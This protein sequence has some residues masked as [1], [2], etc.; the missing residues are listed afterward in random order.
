MTIEFLRGFPIA[1]I[2][3]TGM[4]VFQTRVPEHLLGRA[5]GSLGSLQAAVMLI[6][7]PVAGALADVFS[8]Q[9]VLLAITLFVFASWVISLRLSEE[10]PE[11]EP[12]DDPDSQADR[13]AQRA[14][15]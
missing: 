3:A 10:T 5:L 12:A 2:N 6:E 13:E 4:T 8:A 9:A 15:W 14:R 7:T 1:G 11:P